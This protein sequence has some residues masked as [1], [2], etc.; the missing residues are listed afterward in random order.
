MIS[1]RGPWDYTAQDGRLLPGGHSVRGGGVEV[2]LPGNGS[3]TRAA[4]LA[5]LAVV[6]TACGG[7]SSS[8]GVT[9]RSPIKV[10]FLVPLTGP[11][12][13]NAKAEQQGFVGAQVLEDAGEEARLRSGEPDLVGAQPRKRE[14]PAEPFW[15]AGEIAK[16]LNG[17][18]FRGVSIGR[19]TLVHN[20]PF[21][22]P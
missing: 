4:I 19:S 13:G 17:Q 1:E 11:V 2:K 20:N 9:D 12:S 10:G 16:C 7:G 18:R 22:F 15:L 14:K 8:S 5:A 21:A 3:R 6:V